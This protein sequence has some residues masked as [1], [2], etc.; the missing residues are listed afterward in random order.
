MVFKNLEKIQNEPKDKVSLNGILRS[1]NHLSVRS[2]FIFLPYFSRH[3]I[4]K[5]ILISIFV[6]S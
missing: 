6:G 5:G 1:H 2:V 3:K 4:P